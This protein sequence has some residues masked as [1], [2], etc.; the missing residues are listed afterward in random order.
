MTLMKLRQPV[1]HSLA[2]KKKV[3]SF[4]VMGTKPMQGGGFKDY[5]LSHLGNNGLLT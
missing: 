5:C 4:F 2:L 1:P 3:E